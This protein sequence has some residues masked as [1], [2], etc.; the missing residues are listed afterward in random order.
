MESKIIF[1][2]KI[3]DKY[4]MDIDEL[5]YLI[6]LYYNVKI[7]DKTID[8]LNSKGLIFKDIEDNCEFYT[9]NRD[10]RE[11]LSNIIIDSSDLKETKRKQKDNDRFYNLAIKL[12]EIY[13]AGVK[14]GTHYQWRDSTSII[15]TRLKGLILKYNADFTDEEAIDATKRYVESFNG[16]YTYMQLLKYFISKREIKDG[17]TVENSQLL[18]YIENKDNIT[19][20]NDWVS[21]LR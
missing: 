3:L 1:E 18:S 2:T 12:R 16:N 19:Y 15:A 7:N 6:S 9:L 8:K 14:D 21:T 4:N 17:E 5:L 11:L 10:S 20:N 13:P